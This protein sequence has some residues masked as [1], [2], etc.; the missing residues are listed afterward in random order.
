MANNDKSRFSF[1]LNLRLLFWT[2]L[3][4]AVGVSVH[5]YLVH[6]LNVFLTLKT[7]FFNLIAGNDLYAL[8]PQFHFDYY[9]YGP[10]FALLVGP[11]AILPDVAGAIAWNALNAMLLFYAVTRLGLA[12]RQKALILWIVLIELTTSLQ[13]FQSNG[14]YAALFLLTLA[15]FEDG[16]PSLAALIVALG[17]LVKIFGLAA[18]ILFLFYRRKGAFAFWL[19]VW[20]V[21]L[22]LLPLVVI[23]PEK[24][25]FLYQSWFGLLTRDVSNYLGLSVMGGLRSWFGLAA[26][27]LWVML[28]GGAL[29]LLP[30]LRTSK[31]GDVRF[32]Y[33]HLSSLLLWAVIFNHKAESP[34][35]V[36]AVTGVALWY[37]LTAGHDS[38]A[39]RI[40]RNILLAFVLVAT[41]LSATDAFPAYWRE[42]VVEPYLLKV[43]PCILAWL[44]LQGELLFG[45]RSLTD[46]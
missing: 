43:V 7:S 4:L 6:T 46:S 33:L 30:L 39:Y 41:S 1:L 8:Y 34:M 12:E 13:N 40:A 38:A 5:K 9:K 22:G 24:L 16:K 18:G 32:R 26:P 11:I 23:S 27:N 36:I 20:L 25:V 29:T 44:W 28:A 3:V 45:G 19:A 10:T 15:C 14:L 42:A 31:Y 21:V 17:G 37:V 35:F 2:Y